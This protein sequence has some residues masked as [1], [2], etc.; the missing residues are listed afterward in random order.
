[1][2]RRTVLT[3]GGLAALAG[4]IPPLARAAAQ[5][6]PGNVPGERPDYTIRI[7]A[8]LVQLHMDFGFMALFDYA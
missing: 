5:T 1:M 3:L 7:G 6:G 2:N 8:G 4:A